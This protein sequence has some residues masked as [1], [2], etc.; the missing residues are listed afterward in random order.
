[1][2]KKYHLDE[3][4]DGQML[5]RLPGSDEILT[6]PKAVER[7][8]EE[9]VRKHA[10]LEV[11]SYHGE[12]VPFE[13]WEKLT[14][15]DKYVVKRRL[16]NGWSHFTAVNT[17]G[18]GWR[19]TGDPLS[20]GKDEYGHVIHP[21][22]NPKHLKYDDQSM[23]FEEWSVATGISAATLRA[24]RKRGWSVEKTLTTPVG[25]APCVNATVKA[26]EERIAELEERLAGLEGGSSYQTS[27]QTGQKGP[28]ELDGQQEEYP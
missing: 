6:F 5:L 1:M 8:G 19:C 24:R 23:T 4:Y 28:V 3:I 20:T 9:F 2:S 12:E 18:K 25:R 7:M 21:G 26:L 16:Q 11:V 17:P 15:T 22:P 14:G 13:E 27:P 10:I